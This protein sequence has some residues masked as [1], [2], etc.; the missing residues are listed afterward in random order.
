MAYPQS[1]E[2]GP[3]LTGAGVIVTRPSGSADAV[4]RR[5]RALGGEG[6]ALPGLSLRGP[7][8]PEAAR[9]ALHLAARSNIAVFVSPM[10]VR[11]AWQLAPNL[12]FPARTQVAAVG[13]AT[14][15]ALR[16]RG[17]ARVVEP[18]TS[19]DSEGL[20]ALPAMRSVRGAAVAVIGAPGGRDLM[21]G[22]LRRRGAHVA[23]VDVYRRA[24]PRWTRRHFAALDTAPRP[25]ILL[26][27]SAQALANLAT[28]LPAGLVLALREAEVVVS[29]GRLCELAREH[30]FGRVHVAKS[31]VTD[32]MLTAAAQALARHRL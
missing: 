7:E 30:G 31:A 17:V 14:A 4:L 22:A 11:F 16:R 26:L 19:Q 18:A 29:S 32:D 13:R 10:A 24:A 2:R 23:Q 28:G 8:D 1:P 6:I 15:A 3:D 21:P 9:A 5:I 20:L 12:H 25:R 27:S